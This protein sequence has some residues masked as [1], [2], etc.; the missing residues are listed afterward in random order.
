[1]AVLSSCLEMLKV[2]ERYNFDFLFPVY[3]SLSDLSFTL[4]YYTVTQ[5]PHF[6]DKVGLTFMAVK[7]PLLPAPALFR[8]LPKPLVPFRI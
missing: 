5:F 8:D 4:Q 1:M 6:M 3:E 7:V 2:I